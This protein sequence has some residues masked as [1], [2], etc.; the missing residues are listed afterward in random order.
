M[1]QTSRRFAAPREANLIF[2]QRND[3]AGNTARKRCRIAS[4]EFAIARDTLQSLAHAFRE[5]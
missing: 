5:S 1:R 3:R 2:P 4:R